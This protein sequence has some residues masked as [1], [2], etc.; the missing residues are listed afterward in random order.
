MSRKTI[1]MSAP[2][3]LGVLVLLWAAMAARSEPDAKPARPA[4]KP[5]P[6]RKAAPTEISAAP[7][8]PAAAPRTTASPGPGSGTT[9]VVTS[10]GA[11]LALETTPRTC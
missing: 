10:T 2:L 4:P 7:E 9:I 3:G 11:P 6:L 1:L 5:A 8:T